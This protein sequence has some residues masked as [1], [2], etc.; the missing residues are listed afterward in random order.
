MHGR[1]L[2]GTCGWN[3][4]AMAEH[5]PEGTLNLG[6]LQRRWSECQRQ[7]AYAVSAAQSAGA[8]VLCAR[9]VDEP[10]VGGHRVY[11][12]A[13][14]Y[15]T[16]A[17][18][19]HDALVSLLEHHGASPT[20][21]WN[22]LRPTFEASFYA[23]WLLRPEESITRRRRGIQLEWLDDEAARRF[24]NLARSNPRLLEE[25]GMPALSGIQHSQGSAM[26]R[27]SDTRRVGEYP[28]GQ[29]V[30]MTI[31]DGAFYTAAMATT[32]LRTL[33]WVR[34][35][36]CHRPLRSSAPVDLTPLKEI[37]ARATRGSA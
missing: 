27:V 14:R 21:P 25:L 36:E 1:A 28:G 32:L 22:L 23:R 20:A 2:G 15:L 26:L 6:D 34:F 9:N 5:E 10:Q 11:A 12:A 35:G 29:Q 13:E 37:A 8:Q 7:R 24:G 4:A 16:I 31:N 17:D 18:E 30:H 33:A 3:D 19:N